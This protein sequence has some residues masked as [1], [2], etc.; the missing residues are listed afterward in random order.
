MVWKIIPAINA[1]PNTPSEIA[2]IVSIVYGCISSITHSP[3]GFP[4]CSI[5]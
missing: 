3:V 2:S 1:T 4:L 5:S